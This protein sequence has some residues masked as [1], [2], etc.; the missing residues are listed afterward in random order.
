MKQRCNGLGLLQ[1]CRVL[2]Q[3][4]LPRLYQ[5]DLF[6]LS[7]GYQK[8][9]GDN[10]T[11]AWIDPVFCVHLGVE[12]QVIPNP[13]QNILHLARNLEINFVND[14]LLYEDERYWPFVPCTEQYRL[15]IEQVCDKLQYCTQ[16]QLLDITLIFG[17]K[18]ADIGY[19][20]RLLDPFK[21]LRGI[22]QPRITVHGHEHGTVAQINHP[23]ISTKLRLPAEPRWALNGDF[24]AF[25]E[26]SMTLA[27]DESLPN[28]EETKIFVDCFQIPDET[29]TVEEERLLAPLGLYGDANR[30]MESYLRDVYN[31]DDPDFLNGNMPARWQRWLKK[32]YHKKR[33]SY[34]DHE[35]RHAL[36]VQNPRPLASTAWVIDSTSENKGLRW[37]PE[38]ETVLKTDERDVAFHPHRS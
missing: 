27:H 26:S 35:K 38:N 10:G 21:L 5:E 2:Y 37:I 17:C 32:K 12:R 8:D 19:M 30:M 28:A 11:V 25:L 34:R 36:L 6:A 9:W 16:F 13:P 3:E 23:F 1:T 18:Y 29:E 33:A 24:A 7:V 14:T 31:T 22:R 4:C 15:A 20:E